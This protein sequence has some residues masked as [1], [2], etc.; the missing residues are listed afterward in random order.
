MVLNASMDSEESIAATCRRT[1]SATPAGLPCTLTANCA[2]GLEQL[3][4]AASNRAP[5]WILTGEVPPRR[6]LIDHGP[7][8]RFIGALEIPPG[9]QRDFHHRVKVDAHCPVADGGT[10]R[11]RSRFAAAD[12]DVGTL[13]IAVQRQAVGQRRVLHGGLPKTLSIW[14]SCVIRAGSLQWNFG[15]LLVAGIIRTTG[16]IGSCR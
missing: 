2:K 5:H 7:A 4:P 10:R 11:K 6:C 16:N 15:K 12:L 3:R 9:L 13:R 1:R 8:G 14:F